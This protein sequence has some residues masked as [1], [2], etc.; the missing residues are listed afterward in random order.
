MKKLKKI[1]VI[2]QA[3]YIYFYIN[4]NYLYIKT[5]KILKH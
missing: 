1:C 3:K 5:W 2:V 4:K